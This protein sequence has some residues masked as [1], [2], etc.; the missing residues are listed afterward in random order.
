MF[1]P[2]L[3]LFLFQGDH[4]SGHHSPNSSSPLHQTIA[5][6][7]PTSPLLTGHYRRSLQDVDA[8]GL[9]HHGKGIGR[10]CNLAKHD[11]LRRRS[12]A[13]LLP[14]TPLQVM[15][16]QLVP[17]QSSTAAQQQTPQNQQQQNVLAAGNHAQGRQKNLE[18]ILSK[19][20]FSA[21]MR[22]S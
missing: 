13:C 20:R 7:S 1:N 21:R 5:A 6:A 2:F 12:T 17:S 22:M 19:D 3:S 8:L 15:L 4:A 18:M 14:S 11:D 10:H 9:F 16:P